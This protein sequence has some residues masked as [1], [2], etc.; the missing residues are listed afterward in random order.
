MSI[1]HKQPHE[2]TASELLQ[3]L[4]ELNGIQQP[5]QNAPKCEWETYHKASL[6]TLGMKIYGDK[7]MAR[8][9]MEEKWNEWTRDPMKPSQAAAQRAAG[10][11]T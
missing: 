7:D 4:Y 2:M 8:T 11:Y 9:F 1:A 6:L 5:K 10:T 3:R